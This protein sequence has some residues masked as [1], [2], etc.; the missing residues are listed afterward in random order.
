MLGHICNL[1]VLF[2]APLLKDYTYCFLGILH[3]IYQDTTNSLEDEFIKY[4][5]VTALRECSFILHAVLKASS[6]GGCVL[7]FSGIFLYVGTYCTVVCT[8]FSSCLLAD[9]QKS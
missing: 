8:G 7:V 6:W 3:N 2:T 5:Q 1:S 4:L 9:T